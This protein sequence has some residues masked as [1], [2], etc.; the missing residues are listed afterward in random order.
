MFL[1]SWNKIKKEIQINLSSL[2]ILQAVVQ[3]APLN[4]R[5]TKIIT[6]L[7]GNCFPSQSFHEDLHGGSAFKFPNGYKSIQ[8]SVMPSIFGK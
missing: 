5:V 2:H 7:K 4:A 6:N 3:V 8:R 1:E